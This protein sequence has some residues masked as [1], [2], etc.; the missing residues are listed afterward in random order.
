MEIVNW[1]ENEKKGSW[2]KPNLCAW[3]LVEAMAEKAGD[4]IK[5]VFEPFKPEALEVEFK[6]NGVEL[7]FV[8]IMDKIQ[9]VVE[10]IEDDCRASMVKDAA[11]AIIE[12]LQDQF[13]TYED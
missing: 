6:V 2:D 1:Q 13:K 8:S 11:K 4:D 3:A 10:G 9:S 5:R 7:S 12:H